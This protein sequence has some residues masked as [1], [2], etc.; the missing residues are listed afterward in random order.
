MKKFI[1]AIGAAVLVVGLSVGVAFAKSDK[2]AAGAQ[3]ACCCRTRSRP[4]AGRRR[5]VRP[6]RGV[7]GAGITATIVNAE[8]DAPRQRTQAEQ[9]L[10]A[11]PR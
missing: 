3:T 5:T 2:A 8:G 4:S 10:P 11:V 7:Q 9:C 6:S 1:V